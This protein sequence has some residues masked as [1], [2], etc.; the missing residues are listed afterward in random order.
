MPKKNDARKTT[1]NIRSDWLQKALKSVG[2]AGTQVIKEIMPAT[3]ESIGTATRVA[4]DTARMIKSGRSGENRLRDAISSNSAVKVGK[5]FFQNALADLKSGNLY[6]TDRDLEGFGGDDDTLFGDMDDF[7]GDGDFDGEV[8]IDIDNNIVENNGNQYSGATLKAINKQTEY[9]MKSSKAT[10]DTMVALS[11]SAIMK[12]NDIGTKVISEL[13]SIGSNIAA[14]VEYNSTNMTKFIE[15]S[16]SYYQQMSQ[17]VNNSYR[18]SSDKITADQIFG[19]N[20]G[21]DFDQY[22]NYI[23]QNIKT[24]AGENGGDM[25]KMVLDNKDAFVN[26]PIGMALTWGIHK[27]VPKAIETAATELDNAV[28]E[29]IPSILERV[30]DM[31]RDGSGANAIFRTLGK[32]FGIRTDRKEDFDLSKIEKGPMPYNGMANHTIVEIIPKYLRESNNY[33]RQIAEVVTKKSDAEL[34]KG[35]VGYDWET[36][37]FTKIDEMRDNLYQQVMDSVINKF[38]FSDF[39]KKMSANVGALSKASDREAYEGVL[40]QLY[41][42][43]ER[44]EGQIEYRDKNTKDRIELDKDLTDII[45]SLDANKRIKDLIEASFLDMLSRN[46]TIAL[47]SSHTAKQAATRDRAKAMKD[48]EEQASLKGLYQVY[49]G[50]NFDQ[51]VNDRITRRNEIPAISTSSLIELPL[52]EMQRNRRKQGNS[53]TIIDD[54]GDPNAPRRQD[55]YGYMA[56]FNQR[57]TDATLIADGERGLDRISKAMKGAYGFLGKLLTGS[58]DEAWEEIGKGFRS[59][60]SKTKKFL[61]G[62]KDQQ[63]YAYEG[64]LKGIGNH[65]QESIYAIRRKITGKGYKTADGNTIPDMNDD[66]MGDTIIGKLNNSVNWFKSA[67]SK[68]LFGEKD[69]NGKWVKN[70]K[71]GGEKKGIINV[72]KEKL[73]KAADSMAQGF[74]GWKKALFGDKVDDTGDP[75]EDVKKT[76]ADIK[77]KAQEVAPDTIIGAGGGALIGTLVG[78][79]VAGAII[80]MAGGIAKNSEKFQT[81]LFGEADENG[82]R[83]GGII[84]K[85]IQDY[86]KE[87]GHAIAGG[88]ALGLLIGGPVGALVGMGTSM[89]VKSNAFQKFLFGDAESGQLGI[90]QNFKRWMTQISSSVDGVPSGGKL[91]GMMAIGTAGGG[92]LGAL[93]GGPLVGSVLG[94]GASILASKDNFREWFFGTEW[95]DEEGKTHKREGILGQFKNMLSVHVFT[96][97]ANT[98]KDIGEQFKIFFQ[99]DVL[100]K[101]NILTEKLGNSF[102]GMVSKITGRAMNGLGDLSN[103]IKDNF[104]H[105]F[106]DKAQNILAPVAEAASGVAKSIWTVGRK[107]VTAPLTL[108]SAITSPIAKAVAGVVGTTAKVAFKSV[109]LLIF[110]PIKNLVIKPLAFL[111]KTAFKIVSAPFKL[112]GKVASKVGDKL[113]ELSDRTSL[114]FKKV[115]NDL[116]NKLKNNKLVNTIKG[117]GVDIKDAILTPVKSV[118][119]SVK[120]AFGVLTDTVKKGLNKFFG[121]INPINWIKKGIQRHREKKAEREAELDER[122]RGEKY[123]TTGAYRKDG[124]L[125]YLARKWKEAKSGQAND[126]SDS[127]I[128][129][130]KGHIIGSKL[131]ADQRDKIV[132]ETGL[133]KYI[134]QEQRSKER[135]A[136]NY[137]E[138]LIAKWTKNQ[139]KEFTEENKAL[140]EAEAKRHNQ[141]I[142]W[143]NSVGT[144]KTDHEIKVEKAQEETRRFQVNVE[145][146][147]S[148]IN[149]FIHGRT[150]KTTVAKLKYDEANKKSQEALNNLNKKKDE[151]KKKKEQG[152]IYADKELSELDAKKDAILQ[153]RQKL[154]EGF[155]EEIRNDDA[156][157]WYKKGRLIGLLDKANRNQIKAFNKSWKGKPGNGDLK[158]EAIMS[159]FDRIVKGGSLSK[160]K[161]SFDKSATL[162][163]NLTQHIGQAVIECPKCHA[164]N[165]PNAKKCYHCGARIS[166][167]IPRLLTVNGI[168]PDVPAFASGTSSTKPGPT[169]VGEEGPEAI[170]KNGASSGKLVGLNGP[171]VIQAQGNETIIPNDQ[172][173]KESVD[174][175][176]GLSTLSGEQLDKSSDNTNLTVAERILGILYRISTNV[177]SIDQSTDEIENNSNSDS[178]DEGYDEEDLGPDTSNIDEMKSMLSN[179]KTK[180]GKK[181]RSLARKIPGL[182]LITGAIHGVGSAIHFGK[183]GIG[184]IKEASALK[185]W[186]KGQGEESS[187]EA[188]LRPHEYDAEANSKKDKNTDGILMSAAIV[189]TEGGIDSN[190]ARDTGAIL[191]EGLKANPDSNKMASKL[192][193]LLRRNKDKDENSTKKKNSLW[194]TIKGVLGGIGSTIGGIFSSLPGIAAAATGLMLLFSNPDGLGGVITN[195]GSLLSNIASGLG[196]FLGTVF[197]KNSS[198]NDAALAGSNLATARYDVAVDSVYDLYTP[199]DTINHVQTNA[200]G[201]NIANSVANDAKNVEFVHALG[202]G[203]T[204]RGEDLTKTS[205]SLLNQAVKAGTSAQKW[206]DA[207]KASADKGHGIASWIQGKVASHK[208]KQANDLLD[209]AIKAE[210]GANSFKNSF[211]GSVATSY[212]KGSVHS[213]ASSG[214]GAAGSMVASAFGADG[215]TSAIVGRTAGGLTS[216][217]LAVNNLV[218][219]DK[220]VVSKVSN[221]VVDVITKGLDFLAKKIKAEKLFNKF[222][223]KIDDFFNKVKNF[224]I[225]GLTERLLTK[226]AAKLGLSVAGTALSVVSAGVTIAVGAVSGLAS[227][228]CSVEHLFGVLPGQADTGMNVI[229]GIMGAVF[230]ALEM[231]PAAAFVAILDIIDVIVTPFLG[232]GL[233]Q[234]IARLLYTFFGG[235]EAAARL[236]EKQAAFESERQRYADT[237]GKNLDTAT[238]NDMVNNTDWLDKVWRGGA[239]YD[240]NGQLRYSET[241][242]RID[243]GIKSW[244]VGSDDIAAKDAEGN[245]LRD[246]DGNILSARDQYGNVQKKDMKWGDHVGN[247]ISNNIG[248]FF[249]GKTI[250]ETD[251]NGNAIY[252][253]D[254]NLIVKEKGKNIFERIGDTISNTSKWMLENSVVGGLTKSTTVAYMASDS[255]YYDADGKHYNANGEL[256]EDSITSEEVASMYKA[257]VLVKTIIQNK[258]KDLTDAIVNIKNNVTGA[259]NTFTEGAGKLWGNVKESVSNTFEAIQKNGG[260]FKKSKSEV[261]FDTNGNYYKLRTDGN[262]DYYN[263]AGDLLEEDVDA[264]VVTEMQRSSLLT[265]GEVEGKSVAQTALENIQKGISNLWNTGAEIFN[266]IFGITKSNQNSSATVQAA[267]I[268]VANAA[269]SIKSNKSVGGSGSGTSETTLNGTTYYSQNDPRWK[270]SKFRR[271]DGADDGATMGNTGCGPTAMSMVISEMGKRKTTPTEMARFAQ[272]SGTRDDTGT[273]ADFIDT[274]ARAYGLGSMRNSNPSAGYL[275]SA[276]STGNPMV[277]LGQDDSG[278]R[279]PYTSAGHYIVATGVDSS[280]NVIYNDPRGREYSGRI[281]AEKLAGK[282]GMSWAFGKKGGR[283]IFGRLKRGIGGRGI[284]TTDLD[285]WLKIV[286]AVKAAIASYHG[287]YYSEDTWQ[288]YK[289]KIDGVEHTVRPDCSG[290]VTA[291]LWFYGVLSENTT[292]NILSGCNA[293]SPD[294]K[295]MLSTGFTPRKFTS[296]EDVQVGDII[297]YNGHC[298]IAAGTFVNGHPQVYNCG[299]GNACNTPGISG[300][301]MTGWRDGKGPQLLWEPGPPGP[302]CVSGNKITYY[303]SNTGSNES[304]VTYDV[305]KTIEI[306]NKKRGASSSTNVD[307][308]KANLVT[309]ASATLD[310]SVVNGTSS[311]TSDSS[312]SGSSFSDIIGKLTT[313]FSTIASKLWTAAMTGNWDIDWDNM[314]LDG[315]M[316]TD[317]IETGTAEDIRDPAKITEGSVLG[318]T[319][320]EFSGTRNMYEPRIIV[321][322]PDEYSGNEVVDS[323]ES[324]MAETGK[325]LNTSQLKQ[326]NETGSIIMPGAGLVSSMKYG[327]EAAKNTANVGYAYDNPPIQNKHLY[328]PSDLEALDESILALSHPLDGEDILR[329]PKQ[330]ADFFKNQSDEYVPSINWIKS[331]SDP[332][333]S[334]SDVAKSLSITN[335]ANRMYMD[336]DGNIK[337]YISS[338]NDG[339]Q[340]GTLIN[341][342]A[343]YYS[344]GTNITSKNNTRR[345][346]SLINAIQGSRQSRSGGKLDSSTASE[347]LKGNSN[348]KLPDNSIDYNYARALLRSLNTENMQNGMNVQE[349]SSIL[350]KKGK[351]DG[352]RNLQGLAKSLYNDGVE[353]MATRQSVFDLYPEASSM[354]SDIYGEYKLAEIKNE[355]IGGSGTGPTISKRRR[356]KA[357]TPGGKG[358]SDDRVTA[359]TPVTSG[360]VNNLDG[361]KIIEAVSNRTYNFDSSMLEMLFE[362]AVELLGAISR[363]TNQLGLLKDIKTELN[364]NNITVNATTNNNSISNGRNKVSQSRTANGSIS[365]GEQTARRIAFGQ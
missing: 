281:K 317:E 98:F 252:D 84:S 247:W 195:I 206:A 132:G 251:E 192:K 15:A 239:Q 343:D 236:S 168:S 45:K 148:D 40:N 199:G 4:T 203:Q 175:T 68:K 283:G 333:V 8:N 145:E 127:L 227:G 17:S 49:D 200:N 355:S 58:P 275:K 331:M 350:S 289:I 99:Y 74:V 16:I 223:S 104:L 80:G 177:E 171:E 89:A 146:M 306:A 107:L 178:D 313:G 46:D 158:D 5:E 341:K 277:L 267:S 144:I 326:L 167:E 258:A 166:R 291:C 204:F 265:A 173:G 295:V 113:G 233:K 216:G 105:G 155:Q 130:E 321:S 50:R 310:D 320:P 305:T 250:Y 37:R 292:N 215:E 244:F 136:L 137:N 87:N 274:S 139:R 337:S 264:E 122:W 162:N 344:K 298:E 69:E 334:D 56:F 271:S 64:V 294:S 119:A 116:V 240:E 156:I 111:T 270:D 284:S 268:G 255:T 82:E 359:T 300:S 128:Y 358:G 154:V 41:L 117:I 169:I 299:N 95:T 77:K 311:E 60:F 340:L 266:N 147:I 53:N 336:S 365:I 189:G 214:A 348:K 11:S 330:Y 188:I 71:T 346:Y 205:N 135:K 100:G 12:V 152:D 190:D 360:I 124:L 88:G 242:N 286:K 228:L 297:I 138:K 316:K 362:K 123:G 272:M 160:K 259:W 184:A 165:E 63:G 150:H 35:T 52:G 323:V 218:K 129:D 102:F 249:T 304:P 143:D 66:E 328:T 172:I 20:G 44:H 209:D 47:G 31:G 201:Q 78:G 357:S 43:M 332:Y 260:L 364:G 164:L 212:V 213:L 308:S 324:W 6:N 163:K 110:K 191:T 208:Q 134:Q 186:R 335:M 57:D 9:Q 55:K 180:L 318:A 39:G 125:S 361:R 121:W 38:Q 93:V 262:Y 19:S 1:T 202:T 280:G 196:G 21:L 108:I 194:D 269:K 253:A 7:F 248:G 24:V 157:P 315:T 329:G 243:G 185:K 282:T 153:K 141:V 263:M 18:D 363:N 220:S 62:E 94:L 170:I 149:D 307:A 159:E 48:I 224:S 101:L 235:E 120:T 179:G 354:V 273:N 79:P 81:W 278:S 353:D 276:L 261:L 161:Q 59:I 28:K 183:V 85:E 345:Y 257:G 142:D 217:A 302:G 312:S 10:M 237:Y 27:L 174:A 319:R 287:G 115:G 22:K 229:A 109:D 210:N 91:G 23:K 309:R 76:W 296:W 279:S 13:T 72:A 90:T 131:S 118:M 54:T 211:A 231:S 314:N 112:L 176:L 198:L 96:P 225:K 126:Y 197:N 290:F 86:A 42:A 34:S 114:F 238:F 232:M 75:K 140:A 30:G 33:L 92:L 234:G 25:L 103:Y 106:I 73:S 245:V 325:K 222:A 256:L 226:A 26:N 61:F 352:F 254:G 347:I 65:M 83:T 301:A 182:G 349:A 356:Y 351:L 219:G 193:G 181:L 14:L 221:K 36:G 246:K 51:Y 288:L 133:S 2:A 3:S 241:G 32:I 29:F 151:A 187:E 342:W 97:I 230:G 339:G 303:P 70:D 285:R 67:I 293:D 207:S 322:N 327:F 338:L